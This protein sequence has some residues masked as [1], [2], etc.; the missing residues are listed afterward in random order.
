[1]GIFT[2]TKPTD[3]KRESGSAV[4]PPP[5]TSTFVN[6][7]TALSLAAVY[8]CVSII[9]ATGSQLPVVV[10][11]SGRVVPSALASQPDANLSATEFY[12]QTI[13]SLALHGE[14]FWWVTRDNDGNIKNLTVMSPHNVSVTVDDAPGYV[15]G[16]VRYD[17]NGRTVPNSSVKHLRLMSA[18]GSYRGVGPIQSARADVLT[19]MRL[20]E[21]GDSFLSTGGIPTGLLSSDQV[22]SQDQADAYRTKWDEAQEARGL[23]VL[24]QGLSYQAISLN[25]ADI[26]YLDNQ[27]FSTAQIGRLFGIPATWLGIGIEGSAITYST[28]EG[29]ARAFIQ[30]TLT[31]YLNAIENAISDCLPRGQVAAFKLDA[32]LRADISA[33]VD[34]YVKLAGIGAITAEEVRQSEGLDDDAVSDGSPV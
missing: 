11:R 25:P 7:D 31:Q 12:G 14:A 10:R 19:A 28:S 27:M 29:L 20:R 5:R 34:A 30:T 24:G 26:Q 17:V 23:A 21:Y 32:L 4:L 2:R 33:R 13:T 8:R 22:L 1:M 16:R 18:P 3:E 9:T 6:A 15:N